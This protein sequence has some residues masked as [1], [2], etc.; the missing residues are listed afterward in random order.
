V[1]TR[2][3]AQ[4]QK[5]CTREKLR[6]SLNKVMYTGSQQHLIKTQVWLSQGFSNFLWPCVPSAF[7]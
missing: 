2:S 6:F 5:F 7:R 3:T 4:Q 1:L